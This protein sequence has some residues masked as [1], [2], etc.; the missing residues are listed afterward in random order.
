M[1]KALEAKMEKEQAEKLKVAITEN[2][3]EIYR[4]RAPPS[5]ATRTATSRS[6]SSSI[7]TAATASAAS[8]MTKLI[9]TDPK[10][11]VVFKELPILSKG[12]EEASRVALAARMQGKYWE[13][14]RAMFEAKGR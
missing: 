6:S 2:A 3:A 1:Q 11:R 9:E 8:T 4:K 10:V 14:H 13:V 12:S 5:P 7:T